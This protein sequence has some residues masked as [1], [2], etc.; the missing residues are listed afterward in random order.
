M[1]RRGHIHRYWA[2]WDL[3]WQT[4][5]QKSG[6]KLPEQISHCL[7]TTNVA[8][9]DCNY[10]NCEHYNI[11]YT[12]K[13]VR[14]WVFVFVSG[15]RNHVGTGGLGGRKST[16]R[17]YWLPQASTTELHI[18]TASITNLLINSHLTL[19]YATRLCGCGSRLWM[20]TDWLCLLEQEL[21]CDN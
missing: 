2:V 3:L 17:G 18:F 19:T 13:R 11:H 8:S 12:G 9:P 20:L 4:D 21:L 1:N 5:R 6:N 10:G 15:R 7:I 14:G 16:R